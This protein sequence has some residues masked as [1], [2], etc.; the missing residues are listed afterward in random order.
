LGLSLY[1]T[2]GDSGDSNV[3]FDN[4][5]ILDVTPQLDQT[6]VPN[7][8]GPNKPGDMVYTITNTDDL[9][10]KEGWHF[11]AELPDGLTVTP[12]AKVT[13]TCAAAT[14]APLE[15][16]DDGTSLTAIGSLTKGMESCT[17]TVPVTSD[18]G[19]QEV[20]Q[21]TATPDLITDLYALAAPGSD[22]LTVDNLVDPPEITGPADGS[23][24]TDAR[25]E[26]TGT[27]E[28]GATVVVTTTTDPAG[29]CAEPDADEATCEDDGGTLGAATQVCTATVDDDG[30][31][32][33]TP[34][35]PLPEGNQQLTAVQ[36]DIVDNVSEPSAPV[37]LLVDTIAPDKPEIEY[38][39]TGD[40]TG[41]QPTIWG[42]GEP[43]AHL[44]VTEHED[45]TGA[46]AEPDADEAT[47]EDDG[48]TLAVDDPICEADV[49][50]LGNW[51]CLPDDVLADGDHTIVA[52]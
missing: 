29:A 42:S 36:T 1:T 13:S 46:C 23:T 27:G 12:G 16:S 3:V 2:G 32:A 40:K 24:L 31:W 47:C 48:G 30:D 33:C 17:I 7:Y 50:E 38:P 51:Q 8:V 21:Y 4:A 9:L 6:F 25:P 18:V 43:G 22:T 41:A 11:T 19:T 37:H 20:K 35:N 52:T 10:A 49:D 5:Q 14:G 26:I 28:P 39:A 34:T 44:V 15:L 45:A